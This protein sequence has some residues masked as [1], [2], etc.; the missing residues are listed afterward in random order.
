MNTNESPKS[1]LPADIMK[2]DLN[3]IIF[4]NRNKEY[5]AYQLRKLYDRYM[6]RG[7]LLTIFLSVFLALLPTIVRIVRAAL[8]K[9]EET[10]NVSVELAEPPPLDPN[11]PPPPPPP[12]VEPPPAKPTIAFVAPVV[13]KDEEVIEEVPPP[14]VEEMKDIDVSTKTQEGADNGVAEGIGDEPTEEAPPPVVEEKVEK[15]QEIFKV[16][17]QMPAFEGGNAALF[18]YLGENLKYPV[19]ARENGVEGTVVVQFVVNEDGSIVTPAVVRDIGAGCGEEALRVVK[20]MPRW[21]P[22]K[23]RGKAVRVQ[24]NLPI[25]FKLE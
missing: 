2:V 9:T 19:M 11:Q 10:L 21:Q 13:K 3:D 5:G 8:P 14:T 17:E 25:R 6:T 16:V 24:F 7:G 18:K 23:Q 20:G 4:Q 12:P 1:G 22:G 15:P